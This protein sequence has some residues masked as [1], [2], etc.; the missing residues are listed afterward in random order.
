MIF[1]VQISPADFETQGGWRASTSDHGFPYPDYRESHLGRIRD[2]KRQ[3]PSP[4]PNTGRFPEI[5]SFGRVLGFDVFTLRKDRRSPPAATEAGSAPPSCHL[6]TA[7]GAPCSCAHPLLTEP[8]LS[9]LPPGEHALGQQGL[10]P[11]V[12]GSESMWPRH[13]SRTRLR[14]ASC[15]Y[16][17]RP[18]REGWPRGGAQLARDFVWTCPHLL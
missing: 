7:T 3:T 16:P 12:D 11:G 9:F 8:Q 18:P 1:I 17:A 13:P 5:C 15:G 4:A 2:D 14:K 10:G 6:R